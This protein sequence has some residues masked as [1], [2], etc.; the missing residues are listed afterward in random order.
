[1]KPDLPS[2][3][4]QRAAGLDRGGCLGE[5]PGLTMREAIDAAIHGTNKALKIDRTAATKRVHRR[6]SDA[7]PNR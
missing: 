3:A 7:K 5:P 6:K 1:M 2:A 4:D